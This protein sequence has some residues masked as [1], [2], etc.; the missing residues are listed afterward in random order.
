MLILKTDEFVYAF[1]MHFCVELINSLYLIPANE[2]KKS[3]L[4][5]VLKK[6]NFPLVTEKFDCHR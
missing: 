2:N 6:A 5:P 3:I 1:Y 4:L